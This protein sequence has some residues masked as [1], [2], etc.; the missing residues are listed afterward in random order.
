MIPAAEVYA[1]A[2][3]YAG[4]LSD[5][6]R[7]LLQVL[8]AGV[9]TALAARLRPGLTAAD[10]REVFTQAAGLYALAALKEIT[11]GDAPEQI[12]LGDLTLRK[13]FSDAGVRWL[14]RQADRLM[15]PYVLDRF[16]FQGV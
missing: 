6:Q 13:P 4:N 3:E 5:D 8:S 10:C 7:D 2:L 14:T 12:S 9:G 16:I 11:A 15:A 1:C